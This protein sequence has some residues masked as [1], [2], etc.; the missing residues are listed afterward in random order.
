MR[1]RNTE[2]FIMFEVGIWLSKKAYFYSQIDPPYS[3]KIWLR[4]PVHLGL[5]QSCRPLFPFNKTSQKNSLQF[6]QSSI[7]ILYKCI[8]KVEQIFPKCLFGIGRR[9]YL[10]TYF[11]KGFYHLSHSIPVD[12]LQFKSRIINSVLGRSFFSRACFL[13]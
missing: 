4:C 10:S 9:A 12:I 1:L 11:L 8:I 2:F 3:P 7:R 5:K 13:R 6:C